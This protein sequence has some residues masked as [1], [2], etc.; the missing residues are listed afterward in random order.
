MNISKFSDYF[1]SKHTWPQGN[2]IVHVLLSLLPFHRSH[3]GGSLAI[4]HLY[5]FSFVG[6]M[7]LEAFHRNI[8]TTQGLLIL[9]IFFHRVFNILGLEVG[10]ISC[11]LIS[12]A[13]CYALFTVKVPL[14]FH[15]HTNL[16]LCKFG[17]RGR[18]QIRVASSTVKI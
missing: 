4:F 13:I 12:F 6:R 10:P 14:L 7:L 1:P 5:K 9:Q 15:A 3:V 17:R 2:T 11:T 18:P 16:S 8:F